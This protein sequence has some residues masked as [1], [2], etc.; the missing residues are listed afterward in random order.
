M[1]DKNGLNMNFQNL[2]LL[3]ALLLSITLST[4][5]EIPDWENPLVID[6]NKEPGRSIFHSYPNEIQAMQA[7]PAQS[8]NHISLDGKWHFNLALRPD[9]RPAGFFMETYDVSS[10]D[11]ID[12]PGN[13]EVQG[14]DYPI[15]VNHPYEFA[16]PRTPVS[17]MING[18]EPPKVP[19]EYNPVGSY[20][21][22]FDIPANWQDREVFIHFGSVKSAFYLWINGEMLGYSQGSKLPA[23][24]NISS[25]IRPGSKNTLAVEVYRWSD[26]SYLE[27]QDFWRIS[28]IH[29][30]V[31]LYSQPKLRI[32]DFEL[33]SGLDG[34]YKNGI[35]SVFA[36]VKNGHE[37]IQF[38]TL[39][40]SLYKNNFEI[41]RQSKAFRID[42]GDEQTIEFQT[43]IPNVK[44]WTAES[45]ELYVMLITLKDIRGNILESTSAKT[46]FRTVEIK[47]CQLLINGIPITLRGVNIHEHDPETGHYIPEELMLRDIQLMKQYNINAVRLSHYPFP[48]R[49]YELCDEH[50]LYIVDEANIESHGMYYG[51]RSLA[52]NKDFEL[53]HVDRMVRMVKRDKN[54]PSVI[55]WSMGNEAGNGHNF[56]KGYEAIK[57]ADRSKRPVQY[58]RVERNR[59][60]LDFDWNT[61]IIVPQYP[62]PAT[63]KFLGEH[64]LDRPVIPSEYAHAMG[65]S[66]GNLQEYWDE[67]N[68]YPQLQGGF[69]WDWV[70]QA[71][72]KYDES[73]NR[74]YAYGGHFGEGLPSDGNFL[75]N[76]LVFPDRNIKPILHEVKKVQQ[77]VLF[78]IMGVR[79]NIARVHIENLFDFTDLKE[80]GISSFIKADGKIVKNI[81]L[82]EINIP[83][84]MG[85]TINIDLKELVIEDNTE[86]F[87]HFEARTKQSTSMVPKG[88][89]IAS[90]QFKL[91]F[92]NKTSHIPDTLP[93]LDIHIENDL[94]IVFNNTVCVE[95]DMKTGILTSYIFEGHEFIHNNE[96]PRPDLWRAVTDN[97]FGNR[98]ETKNINWKKAGMEATL[99]KF[100]CE[101]PDT[102][103]YR[104]TIDWRLP[105]VVSNYST[106]YTIYGDG[107]LHIQNHLEASKTEIS[108]L[109]RMG[110]RLLIN[111]EFENLTWF[112]RGPWENYIDRRSSAFVDLYKSNTSDQMVPYIRP[113]ENGNK[114]AVRWAALTNNQ[115]IG[116]LA[117]SD[118]SEVRDGFEMTAMP[119]LSSDFDAAQ[120]Y[121][122]GPLNKELK[123]ISEV[124]PLDFI[125]WNI[126]FGQR[127]LG[128]IDSWHSKPLE[129]YQLKANKVYAYGFTLIPIA[130]V[131]TDEIIKIVKKQ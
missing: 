25:H 74:S 57:A 84:Q 80:I 69:I 55:I 98:M 68:K 78:R 77:P 62:S 13:W 12:V 11:K 102:G 117:V 92:Y 120:D 30:S 54:H 118:H 47:R 3:T 1:G 8:G 107:R 56:Y 126:D 15:Y 58:E 129:K 127:G 33:V 99:A 45:P 95:I 63:L 100:E 41:H 67:I 22:D 113:Q 128:G 101:E 27:C 82:P 17:E 72:W 32:R 86:Y 104:V 111:K 53:A 59:W 116:I 124:K 28:G 4:A 115:G 96:G 34:L 19:R 2:T 105:G 39:E 50:G 73:G 42:A 5:Q 121:E 88:H 37:R 48:Q 130:T 9:E 114:T 83:A 109:P 71:L 87:L 64:R 10:W 106:I 108:D 51:E 93:G 16:D 125:R 38:A 49:W 21:H 131:E 94:L 65:N 66:G 29:R 43:E 14:Y 52:H 24:F 70:D 23:E 40:I 35:L 123:L 36:D 7:N 97:D 6:R 122:Y 60:M 112:G 81:D 26:A 31:F 20:R 75:L 76:G 89:V 61:D 85:K 46:G 103:Q 119:Y 18:P 90:E 44:P 79:E 110:M 91:P